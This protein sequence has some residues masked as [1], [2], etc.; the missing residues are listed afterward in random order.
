M[1]VFQQHFQYPLLE[2]PSQTIR[3]PVLN[4]NVSNISNSN[5]PQTNALLNAAQS[6]NNSS[7][8][9]TATSSKS[10]FRP[11]EIAVLRMSHKVDTM[12]DAQKSFLD[13]LKNS[14]NLFVVSRV[15]SKERK[16]KTNNSRMILFNN[17]FRDASSF[18]EEFN[19]KILM[20]ILLEKHAWAATQSFE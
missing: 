11:N 3:P 9:N 5:L 14:Q 17:I 10:L 19:S 7:K 1:T 6:S 2:M 12:E 18:W 15:S 20:G 16:L 4:T 13:S 8:V